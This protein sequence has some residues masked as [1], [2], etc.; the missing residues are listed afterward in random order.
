MKMKNKQILAI[1]N[2]IRPIK[3]K[4]L[5]VKIGFA[6]NKNLA[7]MDDAAKAYEEE[8]MKI[9]DRY[10]EKDENGLKTSEDGKEY[11]LKDKKAYKE[12]MDELWEI[13]TDISIHTVTMNDV[14]KCDSEKFDALTPFELEILEFMIAE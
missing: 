6:I 7:T 4:Q 8:R 2:N 11:L 14:E 12:A 1:Y 13:E 10:G 3:Q 9:L 5:P